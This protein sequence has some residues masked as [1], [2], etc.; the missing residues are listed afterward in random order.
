M[1]SCRLRRAG[2]LARI[3]VDNSFKT[4]IKFYNINDMPY[5]T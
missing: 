4:V 1:K 5:K 3:W 2:Q